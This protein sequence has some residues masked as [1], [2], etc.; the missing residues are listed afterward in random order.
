MTLPLFDSDAPQD[1][2][3]G[4]FDRA[5][6]AEALR[7]LAREDIWIGTSSWKYPGWVGQIYTHDRYLTRGRFS[8]KRFEA[9]CLSEYAE[10]FPAVCGDF[11]FY[12]F[13]SP[14]YWAKLFELAPAALRF[15]LKVPE[16]VT[17][18]RFPAHT[19]YGARG[20]TENP[21]FLDPDVFALQFLE[22]LAP[23]R[24]RIGALIFEFG[25]RSTASREFVERLGAFLDRLPR[26]FRYSVEVRNREFLTPRYFRCLAEHE[27]AHVFNAWTRMPPIA[28]QMAMPGAFTTDFTVSRALLRQGRAYAYAVKSFE[29]YSQIRDKNPETRDALAEMIRRMR[30]ERRSAYIFVNNR[31]EGNSPM[32]IEA[33]VDSCGRE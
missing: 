19:R 11:S 30:G 1:A 12:Q 14:D 21:L 25:P 20:G 27:V 10:V 5:A 4:D 18:E 7:T 6:L 3:P 9:E 28:E 33:V 29:P 2:N 8:K 23:Y 16:D 26:T 15:V 24:D 31:F 17:V 22:P 13:P 32:T